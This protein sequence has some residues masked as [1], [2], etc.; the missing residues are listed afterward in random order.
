MASFFIL[1]LYPHL[2]PFVYPQPRPDD[3]E[4]RRDGRQPAENCASRHRYRGSIQDFGGFMM[5]HVRH[6]FVA[7]Q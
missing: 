7:K 6:L 2:E 3:R 1:P 5:I 4:D